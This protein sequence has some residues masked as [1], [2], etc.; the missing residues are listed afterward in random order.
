M[1]ARRG[2]RPIGVGI[3][4]LGFM[5]RT[6]LRA[7]RSAAEAGFENRLAAVCDR[8]PERRAGSGG[9][10]GNLEGEGAQGPLFDPRSVRAYEDPRELLADPEVEVVSICTHTETHV[11]LALAA[12][13][14]GKHVLV[15][16][17]LALGSAAIEPLARAAARARTLCMPAL[18]MRFWPGWDLVRERIAGGEH[19]RARSAVFRRLSARPAWSSDFYADSARSGGALLDLHVHDADFV[20]WC[21]GSPRE[22]ISAGSLEHI[23]TLYR[24]PGGPAHVVAEGGWDH[25]PGF[26]FRM[27]YTVVFEHATLDFDSARKDPL[28]LSRAGRSEPI[29]LPP[30]SGYDAE[31]RHMLQCIEHGTPLRA[32]VAD[33]LAHTRLIEA[34]RASLESGRC[35]PLA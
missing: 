4:G 23:T 19:G 8:D 14:A 20:L 34:E 15:E 6:H 22:L 2:S 31:V 9:P 24:Y 33:A 25:S 11:P 17:P 12:L 3:L 16:K 32:T 30:I 26:E 7:W 1:S 21:F 18:C 10:R 28:L 29:A 13:E 35:V 5:G 27:G